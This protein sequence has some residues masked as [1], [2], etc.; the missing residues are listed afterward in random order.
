[1]CP[2]CTPTNGLLP[3]M[4]DIPTG[5]SMLLR[6]ESKCKQS[7]YRD[8]DLID[9]LRSISAYDR[10]GVVGRT[11]CMT[12]VDADGYHGGGFGARAFDAFFPDEVHEDSQESASV[13]GSR[14]LQGAALIHHVES[15]LFV[16]ANVGASAISLPLGYALIG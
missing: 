12:E 9:I 14:L 11:W 1:M 13:S 10:D 5:D 7:Q 15:G 3:L 6:I 4:G 8:Y 2:V 16:R